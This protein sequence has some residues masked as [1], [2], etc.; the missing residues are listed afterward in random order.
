MTS[1]WCIVSGFD[2]KD[3]CSRRPKD[4][5]G[6][7]EGRKY[8]LASA[9]CALSDMQ[10]KETSPSEL[11][12][13]GV[14]WEKGSL[15]LSE[16]SLVEGG[17]SASWHCQP[18]GECFCAWTAGT[19]RTGSRR[20]QAHRGPEYLASFL[21]HL[22]SEWRRWWPAHARMPGQP[23]L[24]RPGVWGDGWRAPTL[25][26]ASCISLEPPFLSSSPLV[27]WSLSPPS[28]SSHCCWRRRRRS[29]GRSSDMTHA[30]A[31]HPSSHFRLSQC[32]R[33]PLASS[34]HIAYSRHHPPHHHHT[35]PSVATRTATT[36]LVTTT[37]A[38]TSPLLPLR[39]RCIYQVD[40]PPYLWL[41]VCMDCHIARGHDI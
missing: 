9:D 26:S 4:F 35:F 40:R 15:L 5:T 38:A 6:L 29:P 24:S 37:C 31:R 7:R 19:C 18:H 13:R 14:L 33:H 20:R 34:G 2:A 27:L 41:H 12:V 10:Q 28:S 8:R 32:P 22:A 11:L 1:L 36:C 23:A 21:D 17:G 3:S 30:P 25:W 16:V 39:N